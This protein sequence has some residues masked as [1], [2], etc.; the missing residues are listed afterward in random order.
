MGRLC[1]DQETVMPLGA[2]EQRAEEMAALD[3]VLHRRRTDP[4]IGEWL[5]T[6]EAEDAVCERH[7]ALIRRRFE[8]T[9]KIPEKL[10]TA[11]ARTTSLA[12]RTWAEARE[13]N[14]FD[15]FAPKLEEVLGLVREKAAALAGDNM[16][17]DALLDEYEPG[18]T[19]ASL[20]AMFGAL[21][22]RLVD[23]RDRVMGSE[24]FVPGL[25]QEFSEDGQLAVSNDLARAFGY[26][27][28]HGRIDKAVH[29]FSSGSGLDVR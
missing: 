5:E 16:L 3:G 17:Y 10:S 1:W 28:H 29:P 8:K 4:R 12:H 18:A 25:D 15:L 19:E 2:G 23:L 22:P 14:D 26:D 7:L 13:T 27:T 24:R 6:A 20:T 9:T 11:L 21:H